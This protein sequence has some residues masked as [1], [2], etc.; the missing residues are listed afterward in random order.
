MWWTHGNTNLIRE[1]IKS[2]IISDNG[3][4]HFLQHLLSFHLLPKGVEIEIRNYNFTY[5][6]RPLQHWS[7]ELESNSRREYLCAFI[8]CLCCSVCR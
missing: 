5:S 4:Y 7:C 3:C 1:E 2:V 8:R 6:I